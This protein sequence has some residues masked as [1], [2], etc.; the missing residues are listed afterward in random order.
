MKSLNSH[1]NFAQCIGILAGG[2]LNKTNKNRLKFMRR[3]KIKSIVELKCRYDRGRST[4]AAN[5]KHSKQISKRAREE[6]GERARGR[7]S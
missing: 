3:A 2:T 6:R 1:I 7:G 5:A 4:A